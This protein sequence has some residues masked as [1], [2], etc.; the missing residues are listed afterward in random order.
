MTCAVVD[1]TME[2]IKEEVGQQTP[3]KCRSPVQAIKEWL[4]LYEEE[5]KAKVGLQFGNLEECEKFYKYYAHHVGFSVRRSSCK[6]SEGVYKYKY[7]VCSKQG[8]KRTPINVNPNL[9]VKLTRE[10]CMQL[11]GRDPEKL[12]LVRKRIQSVLKELKELDG[13]T[14]ESK[15]SELESFIGL[16]APEQIDILPPKYCHSKGSGKQIKGG[17]EIAMEQQ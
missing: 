1:H 8:F 11:A 5:L 10:D 16:S 4:P 7:Y 6:K 17:K 2:A 14:N 12:S 15:I 3:K 9:K 13:G